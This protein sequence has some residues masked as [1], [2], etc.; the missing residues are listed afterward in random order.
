VFQ[1]TRLKTQVGGLQ[2][3]HRCHQKTW[4][5]SSSVSCYDPSV[6]SQSLVDAEFNASLCA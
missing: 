1:N 3:A 2:Q 4:K 5:F 6:V